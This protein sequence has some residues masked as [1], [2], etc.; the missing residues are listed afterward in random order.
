VT[1]AAA[2]DQVFQLEDRHFKF[3]R[4]VILERTGIALSEAKRELVYGRLTRRIRALKLASFDEYYALLRTSPDAE[5]GEFVNAITTNL[6]S[7]FRESHHFEFLRDAAIPEWLNNK[8]R[9]PRIRIWSAGCA[10]GEEPY[11][12]AMTLRETLG[13]QAGDTLVLATDIDTNVLA[14]ARAGIYPQSCGENIPAPYRRWIQRGFDSNRDKL[15]IRQPVAD[16]IRF[17]PLNLM[18]SW[19]VKG[20]LDAVFCRNV[21]IYFD[22][23]TQRRLFA[24]F[25]E[26]ITPGGYLVI[27][28]SETLSNEFDLVGRTIYRKKA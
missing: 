22:K 18:E 11:S 5:M 26:V 16:M 14:T 21:V 25:A 13:T 7:F 20:P 4:A 23:D 12:I 2:L 28:H 10:T 17:N 9:N 1:V 6:T 24:R 15:R 27:G 8:G 3:L 19:P